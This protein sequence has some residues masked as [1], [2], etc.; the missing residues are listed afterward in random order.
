MES[1]PF[2]QHQYFPSIPFTSSDHSILFKLTA[3]SSNKSSSVLSNPNPRSS[4]ISNP[5]RRSFTGNPFAK[6][7]VIAN[8]RTNFPN[9]PANS[10]SDFPR[11]SSVGVRENAG[12]LRDF[13]DD[14]ENGKD[15]ILKPAKVRSPATS[16]KGTKNFMS[17]TISASCKINDSPRKKVLIER[18]EVVPNSADPK[19]NVRKVT[20]AEPLEQNKFDALFDGITPNFEDAP[21]SSSLTSEDLSG[22]SETTVDDINVSLIRN[23]DPD[24]SFETDVNMNVPLVL[25]NDIHTE[26]VAVEPDCVNL[27][28]TFKLSP[29]ATPPVSYKATILAPLDADP[30]MPPYDPK[31]NYLSP[32]PQ[33]LH[34]KPKP[35]VELCSEREI[36]DSIISGSFSDTEVTEDAQSEVSQKES[37]DVSSVEII[38]EE[39]GQISEPSPAMMPEEIVEAKEAPKPRFTVRAKAIALMLL[40]AAVFVSISVTDSPVIDQTVFEDLYR[41]YES[42][43]FSELARANFDRFSQFAKT[44]FDGLARNLHF[45]FTKS[46]SS[47]SEFISEVRGTHNLAK[48]QYYNLTV[49]HEY[50]MV[51]QY[52]IFGGG[53]SK[54][55]NTRKQVWNAHESDVASETNNDEYAEDISA[56]H[57]QVN[58]EQVQQDIGAVTGVE[59]ASDTPQ[60]EEVL[61]AAS[62]T[63]ND[64][65]TEDISAKHHEVYEQ[66]V[67]QDIGA[68]TGVEN[69]L[70][71]PQSEEEQ[72][73]GGGDANLNVENQPSLN[74]EAA[75]FGIEAYGTGDVD[76]KQALENDATDFDTAMNHHKEE[77]KPGKPLSID[78]I[79]GRLEEIDIP[80]RMVLY[81]MLCAG[82]VLIAG[83]AFKWSRIAES[84]NNVIVSS[85]V[86]QPLLNKEL[87][88]NNKQQVSS[89]KVPLRYGTAEMDVL[90]EPCPSEMSS[91]QQSSSYSKKMLKHFNETAHSAHSVEKKRK[92]SYRRESLAS[93]SDY[94]MGSPSYGSLTVY[95]KIPSKQGHGDEDTIITPVRR[96]SRIRN[97]ATSPS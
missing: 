7:S 73:Q 31:T 59:N 46:L 51:D 2:R 12:S 87:H 35:R 57:G 17:P 11:R 92:N 65:Y 66:Q 4:E 6:P 81:F 48:L 55:G 3:M 75:E 30:L 62:E 28:P 14:K 53:E 83:A 34:Y 56:E 40:L 72:A 95:E 86:E 29:T 96:S 23:N 64:E 21:R 68:V 13:M 67:Q 74:S 50:T 15:Q 54:I 91:F 76:S 77:G 60:S 89:D 8:P 70:N 97:L 39:E 24:F 71:A 52:P 44:N 41:V 80:P 26:T 43:E 88:D 78:A 19:S 33:F 16:S 69:A 1:L 82:T 20:F 58:E 42:S 93:S 38:K 32:R 18:N 84:R 37:E 10:P 27:D 47:M 9:T 45:W 22:E 79:R 85:S 25:E 49:L 36:E 94:S 90:E 61:D 5:M 63:D